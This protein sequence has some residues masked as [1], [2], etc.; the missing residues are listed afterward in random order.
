M[1]ARSTQQSACADWCAGVP[2]GVP[3]ARR[4][5]EARRSPSCT[6]TEAAARVSAEYTAHLPSWRPRGAARGR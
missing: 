3:V 1:Q 5:S 2:T 6:V 4:P